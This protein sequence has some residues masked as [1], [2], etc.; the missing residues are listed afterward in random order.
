MLHQTAS[1]VPSG[2]QGLQS[3]SV[4]RGAAHQNYESEKHERTGLE[5]NSLS[6]SP[7]LGRFFETSLSSCSVLSLL[8]TSFIQL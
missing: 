7:V 4:I 5:L 2:W 3:T 8:S 1:G 6:S